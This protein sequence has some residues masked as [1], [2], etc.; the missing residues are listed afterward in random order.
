MKIEIRKFKILSLVLIFALFIGSTSITIFAQ[1]FENG[2]LKMTTDNEEENP[3]TYG[4]YEYYIFE[5][6]TIT[7]TG[8]SGH[9]K[10]IIIPSVIDNKKVVSIYEWAFAGNQNIIS[11]IIPEGIISIGSGAFSGCKSLTSINLPNTLTYIRWDA[12]RHC[13]NLT[14]VI[15]PKNLKILDDKAFYECNNLHT[16]TVLSKDVFIYPGSLG[17]YE[18]RIN[19]ESRFEKID[20]FNIMGHKGSTAEEYA[21]IE[22]F[23]FIKL[24]DT[25]GD[26]DSNGNINIEDAT[27]IQK[28]IVDLVELSDMQ[29]IVADVNGDGIVNI[30][31][32]TNIQKFIAEIITSLG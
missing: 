31:D 22:N 15:I 13:E 29:L 18:K 20:N 25:M 23:K 2:M 12:F 3:Y 30:E 11:L 32:V 16:V 24:E 8:Y 17:F 5:D 26:I 21:T 28:Y 19:D 1:S 14:S 10:D 7:I 27:M 9:D 4:N 6:D